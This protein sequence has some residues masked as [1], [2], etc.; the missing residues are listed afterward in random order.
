MR[1]A[2]S[3]EVLDDIKI[4]ALDNGDRTTYENADHIQ[5][6]KDMQMFDALGKTQE[7]MDTIDANIERYDTYEDSAELAEKANEIRELGL[8]VNEGIDI[9]GNKLDSQ[10]LKETVDHNKGLKDKITDYLEISANLQDLLGDKFE[11]D[12]EMAEM[13]LL[14]SQI[15]DME[16]RYERDFS[17]LSKV[18]N[19]V[20]DDTFLKTKFDINLQGED[21]SLNFGEIVQRATPSELVGFI[22]G[23]HTNQFSEDYNYIQALFKSDSDIR[24][25]IKRLENSLSSM[26]DNI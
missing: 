7:F 18:L 2:V 22:S 13:I 16:A 6:I 11:S 17:E 23:M 8:S 21:L 12:D 19:G 25:E 14:F 3:R 5:F 20:K 24:S 15:T 26:Y 1:N 10:I 9:F 4:D